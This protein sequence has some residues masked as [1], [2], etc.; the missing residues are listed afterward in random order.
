MPYLIRLFCLSFACL[1]LLHAA[2]GSITAALTPWI[3]RMADQMPSRQA[4]NFLFSVRMFPSAF[5]CLLVAAFCAPSYFRLEPEG[6]SEGVGMI[7][8]I[9]AA[10]GM[11][12]AGISI[13]RSWRAI[14]RSAT[15]L[16]LCRR[17]VSGTSVP[18]EVASVWVVEKPAPLVVA[19]AGVIRPR[20][21]VSKEIL[22]LL[23]PAQLELAL[24]HERAHRVSHDNLKRLLVILAPDLLP[25][26][27][28][29]RAI[30]RNRAKFAEWAADDE[31][32]G[33]HIGRALSLAATLV[34]VARAGSWP[35]PAPLLTSFVDRGG[36][37][38]EARVDRLLD[39][40][41]PRK[42]TGGWSWWLTVTVGAGIACA[43]VA[44]AITPS[45][46][47][48]VHELLEHLIA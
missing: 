1:F 3:L 40:E 46:L 12:N 10:L 18:G 30:E 27:N 45:V 32:A 34:T 31:A 14:A 24:L 21:I 15:F 47:S 11:A 28:P 26:V 29:W 36:A 39:A 48:A 43:V 9:A 19:Q 44:L 23:S 35:E 22:N 25:F 20:L 8:V 2:V 38:L 16:R 4:A 42:K 41:S 37:D 13:V 33:G 6:A 7:C 5:A 17:S